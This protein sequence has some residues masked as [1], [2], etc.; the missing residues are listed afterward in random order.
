M[1]RLGTEAE[2]MAVALYAVG[3]RD[4]IDFMDMISECNNKVTIETLYN[5]LTYDSPNHDQRQKALNKVLADLVE[6]KARLMGI[7]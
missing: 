2:R 1:D 5:M 7:L 6:P 4:V 3:A